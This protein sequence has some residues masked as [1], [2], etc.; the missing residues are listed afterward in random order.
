MLICVMSS[1]SVYNTLIKPP[2]LCFSDTNGTIAAHRYLLNERHG[3]WYSSWTIGG[4][5]SVA[6]MMGLKQGT[7]EARPVCVRLH[8]SVPDTC[9]KCP[10]NT[11]CS[12][13]TDNPLWL[14]SL[15]LLESVMDVFCH[16]RLNNLSEIIFMQIRAETNRYLHHQTFSW[17]I[18]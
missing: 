11:Q 10:Y 15:I 7:T 4:C 16:M 13:I 17:W 2:V 18:F 1:S 3:L 5:W 12:T 9:F 8:L 6:T 14:Y